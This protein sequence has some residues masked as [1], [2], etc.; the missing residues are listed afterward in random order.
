MTTYEGR[1]CGD[2]YVKII[3]K[4][5]KTVRPRMLT[6]VAVWL[7]SF[8]FLLS[9]QCILP[10]KKDNPCCN[11]EVVQLCYIAPASPDLNP[12]ENLWKVLKDKL[13]GRIMKKDELASLIRREWNN[14]PKKLIRKLLN[15]MPARCHAV[16][17]C[18]G[19]LTKY[20]T[21][22]CM[23]AVCSFPLMGS[24]GEFE[25]EEQSTEHSPVGEGVT[26]ISATGVTIISAGTVCIYIYSI[27]KKTWQQRKKKLD[28]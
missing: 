6:L 28:R 23:L 9:G 18:N 25:D 26:L 12:L 14:I 22:P 24:G 19:G 17:Q 4:F 13:P 3:K 1:L 20:W 2:D 21:A 16:I 5:H 15:S 8:F 27:G 10:H 11:T 7:L